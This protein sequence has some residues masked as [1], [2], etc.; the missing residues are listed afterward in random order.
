ML[1]AGDLSLTSSHD[2]FDSPNTSVAQPALELAVQSVLLALAVPCDCNSQPRATWP[3]GRGSTPGGNAEELATVMQSPPTTSD[4]TTPNSSGRCELHRHC[5]SSISR[6]SEVSG[7]GAHPP[8][9]G[10]VQALSLK[11]DTAPSAVP[12]HTGAGV[13]G[14]GAPPPMGQPCAE[15]AVARSELAVAM[16]HCA[17]HSAVETL[18]SIHC[19]RTLVSG[20]CCGDIYTSC[21]QKLVHGRV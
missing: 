2:D 13:G 14:G 4:E 15:S 19:Q 18:G 16:H 21:A 20:E 11:K 17:M 3:N 1:S 6:A 5:A 9:A 12:F 8:A 7:V 10:F